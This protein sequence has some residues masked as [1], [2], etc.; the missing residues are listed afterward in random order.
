MQDAS[1]SVTGI[2]DA[3]TGEVGERYVYTPYGTCTILD[4][5]FEARTSSSFEWI[6]GHQGLSYDSEP[7]LVYN[8]ARYLHTSMGRFISRD[9]M[10]YMDTMSLVAAYA[11]TPL[12]YVDPSGTTI[13][14]L[15][16]EIGD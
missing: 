1:F 14:G 11:S 4:P 8:R 9:P 7:G 10:G 5:N 6:V 2:V 12:R 16:D 15:C 3:T 13:E